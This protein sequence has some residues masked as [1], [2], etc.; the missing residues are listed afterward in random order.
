M[1]HAYITQPEYMP[2]LQAEF[3][4]F[5][6]VAPHI[7]TSSERIAPLFAIDTW[8]DCERLHFESIK[9]AADLLKTRGRLW[10]YHGLQAFRRGTLIGESLRLL[11]SKPL[12]FSS[13]P[14]STPFGIYTL[15]D[16]HTLM[17]C[18]SPQKPIPLGQIEFVENKVI[19]PNR[20][21][22]KLWEIF[23]LLKQFPQAGETCLDV[24]ASPGGWSWVLAECGAKVI[25]VDKAPLAPH[26]ATHPNISSQQGSAFALD[27]KDFDPLDWFCSDIICYPK[28]LV[29]LIERWLD[30]G[31][32]RNMICTIK[33][34]G[35]TDWESIRLLQAIP[36]AQVQHLWH[37]KHELCFY[38]RS[39]LS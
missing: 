7:L 9:N 6:M 5:E 8:H 34:Q 17:L 2:L 31:K 26:I 1:Q 4:H 20:A 37:N 3:S 10:H 14:P 32:V 23:T 15:L 33:L 13:L 36:G 35:D 12:N 24:G 22:L 18:Q 39:P 30:S 19:P 27:P 28:R 25:A 11:K 38:H 16:E 21:Y 29:S